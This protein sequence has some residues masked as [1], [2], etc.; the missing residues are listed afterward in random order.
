M[1]TATK[2]LTNEQVWL[3]ADAAVLAHRGTCSQDT[4]RPMLWSWW[5][6]V[7]LQ[8]S[9]QQG[10]C[11]EQSVSMKVL[12]RGLNI[13]ENNFPGNFHISGSAVHLPA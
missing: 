13:H 4:A 11:M 9:F 6:Q 5:N 2:M 8:Y 12:L 3:I 10:K 1:V 7:C